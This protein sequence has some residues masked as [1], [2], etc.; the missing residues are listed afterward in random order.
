[1]TTTARSASCFAAAFLLCLGTAA[2]AND[3]ANL[4]TQAKQLDTAAHTDGTAAVSGRLVDTFSEF[5][6]S[7]DNARALIIGL[8]DGSAIT[9]T[10]TQPDGS[11]VTTT[12]TPATGKMG[13][14]NVFISVALAQ[15]TLTAQG[16]SSPTPAQIEAALNGGS[17]TVGN[18]PTTATLTGVLTLRA[19]GE[20]WGKVAQ[21]LGVKLGPVL[22]SIRSANARLH[23]DAMRP[24][25][26]SKARVD[27]STRMDRVERP[28]RP[29]RPERPSRG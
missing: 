8:R 3:T 9:L 16:I 20:G 7:T 19:S 4:T 28:M 27:H 18:P 21:S 24:A 5:A 29:E 10:E 6:G 2:F 15:Q 26:T 11:V 14:G 25:Q 22:S 13:Y 1:M 12:F 23:A 17:V